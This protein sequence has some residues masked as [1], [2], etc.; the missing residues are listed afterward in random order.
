MK[1]IWQNIIQLK[2]FIIQTHYFQ[3]RSLNEVKHIAG[4]SNSEVVQYEGRGAY[5]LDK[6]EDGVWRLEVMPDAIQ[7]DN[8]FGR[9]NLDKTVAVINW[10][11]WEMKVKLP[12]LGE[13]FSIVTINRDEKVI[14]QRC[15]EF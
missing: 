5:F 14:K 7:I 6:L 13:N 1:R 12:D 11:K 2:S 10:E 3:S 8:P 4:Y 9:N 15:R